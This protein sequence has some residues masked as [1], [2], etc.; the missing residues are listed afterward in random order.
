MYLEK[1]SLVNFKNYSQADLDFSPD[2]NCFA[3]NNGVGKT[4]LLDAIHYLCFCKSFFNPIDS[5]NILHEAPFFVIQ[6][7]FDLNGEKNEIYCGQ[8]R[9]QKKQFKRNKKEYTR[10]ADHIGLFPCVMISPADS[11]LISEGSEERRKFM[12]SIISQF[13]KKY[14]DDL[15]TYNKVL[16]QRNALLRQFGEGNFFDATSLEVW[17]VQLAALGKELFEKRQHFIAHFIQ[18]F[19]EHYK[20]ISGGNE[21]VN[22]RYVSQL[23][24]GDMKVLMDASLRKDRAVEY[25]TVGIH[26]DDIEFEIGEHPIKKFGS[27]GQ[28]KSLLVALRLAQFDY[29]QKQKNMK[30]VL[31]LDDIY[32]KL[33][34][35][36]VRKLMELVSTHRFGQ[37]FIT[38]TNAKRIKELF[39]GIDTQLKMFSVSKEGVEEA[40]VHS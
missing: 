5:Q 31:L 29:V 32:D 35:S 28:Q 1:L 37:I 14:L 13:D 34:N 23:L 8:K 30:P 17:D 6:G 4:N 9:S 36:R 3:G 10:L 7:I 18:L 38:D 33:D 2:V 39:E 11:E 24:N 22:I 27:Q 19:R 25:T 21:E 26:K 40:K 12:D 20:F 15:I 16:M